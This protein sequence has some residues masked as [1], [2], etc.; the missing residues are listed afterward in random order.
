MYIASSCS[1]LTSQGKAIQRAAEKFGDGETLCFTPCKKGYI[2]V[3]DKVQMYACPFHHTQRQ[4]RVRKEGFRKGE[5][6]L[7]STFW[8]EE[9]QTS[10]RKNTRQ[11]K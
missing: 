4:E 2:P 9:K 5:A 8:D 10:V 6:D 7:K 3:I 1:T 11:S